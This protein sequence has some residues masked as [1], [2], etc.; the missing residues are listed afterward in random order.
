[1][2]NMWGGGWLA[3]VNLN[4]KK[5]NLQYYYQSGEMQA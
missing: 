2:Q 5:A 3:L 1:M 4:L